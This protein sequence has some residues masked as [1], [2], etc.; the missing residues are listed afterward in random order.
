MSDRDRQSLGLPPVTGPVRARL[1]AVRAR[2]RRLEPEATA[3]W[4]PGGADREHG[5]FHGRLDRRWRPVAPTE[6]SIVQQARHLWALAAYAERRGRSALVDELAAS[7]YGF[8]E[9]AFR[10]PADGQYRY[11][12]ARDG[13]VVDPV[14]VLYGQG[15][16]IYGLVGYGHVYGANEATA[17][18][19]GCFESFDRARHD[20]RHGGYDETGDPEWVTCG[21]A[22]DTNTHIHLMEPLTVL[23]EVTGDPR[24]RA[25]LAELVEIVTRRLLQPSGYVHPFFER[26]FTPFGPPRVSYGHDIETAWLVLEAARALGEPVASVRDAAVRMGEAAVRDG[27]DR[28]R[29]GL[30]DEGTPGGAVRSREKVW[31]AQFE[32]LPGLLWLYRLTGDEARLDELERTLAFIEGPA[33]DPEHGE[34]FFAVLPS[35]E[36]SARGDHK[37]EI[38][39]ATYHTLRALL[40]V[41]DWIDAW[42]AEPTPDPGSPPAAGRPHAG[43]PPGAH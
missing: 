36:P 33:R 37:G 27:F 2:L 13:A 26:D 3:P 17:A 20:D 14:K 16:A 5:G 18:A 19:L 43:A 40:L 8:I 23:Y 31:W 24:V 38:W 35:G 1:A 30:F 28:E 32:A 34:W 39:K 21:A 22:K 41:G 42:L 11:L 9:R 25:R 29:G 7:T 15:F 12:V 6:K 10:D 4:W